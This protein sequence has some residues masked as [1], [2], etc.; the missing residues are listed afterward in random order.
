MIN[1]DNDFTYS[2]ANRANELLEK[3]RQRG[4]RGKCPQLVPSNPVRLSWAE[5]EAVLETLHDLGFYTPPLNRP[6]MRR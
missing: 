3:K 4:L 1:I 5:V 6:N 2:V